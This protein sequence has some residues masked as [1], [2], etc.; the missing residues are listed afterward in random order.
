MIK[1]FFENIDHIKPKL[2]L[3]NCSKEANKIYDY[4]KLLH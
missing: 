3:F 2:V 1:K 4:I